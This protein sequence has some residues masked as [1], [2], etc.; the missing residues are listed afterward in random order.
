MGYLGDRIHRYFGIMSTDE[1]IE[2]ATG[3]PFDPS[4]YVRYLTN[5]YS[6]IYRL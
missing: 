3:K 1:I 2:N 4:C 5:K 6:E